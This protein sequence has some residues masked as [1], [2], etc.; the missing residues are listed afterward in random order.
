ML[1]LRWMKSNLN[2]VSRY[3]CEVV[4]VSETEAHNWRLGFFSERLQ[5]V[6]CRRMSWM[7]AYPL[8]LR[9]ACATT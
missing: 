3:L 9:P 8:C 2:R 1:V 5:K 4:S 6:S 7:I